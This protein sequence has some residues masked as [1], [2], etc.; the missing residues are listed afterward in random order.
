[1]VTGGMGWTETRLDYEENPDGDLR[2]DRI[3]PF[4]MIWDCNA[5]KKNL[6]D[7]RRFWHVRRLPIN[8][9][10]RLPG[11]P[12]G[13]DDADLNAD[14][15][16]TAVWEGGEDHDGTKVRDRTRSNLGEAGGD[17]DEVVIVHCQWQEV[18][19][20]W[21]VPIPG[22]G[23]K[24]FKP[25]EYKAFKKQFSEKLMGGEEPTDE[26]LGAIRQKQKVWYRAIL[27]NKV[28]V[29]TPCAC[30]KH[31]NFKAITG[32]R[33]QTK[34]QWFGLVRP[35]RDPQTWSNKFFSQILHIINSNAKGGIMA[36]R[37]QAFDNDADAEQSW[38]RQDRITWFKAGALSGPSQKWAEKPQ[39]QFPQALQS[40]MEYAV[41][42]VRATGGVSYE[43]IGRSAGEPR[44]SAPAS[45][46]DDPGAALR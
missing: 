32:K 9:A 44:I 36:E 6:I 4:E 42:A 43:F 1:M 40:L 25:D 45:G 46:T 28:L 18:E 21:S 29:V 35:M 13:V 12:A 15:A 33:H 39:T 27:G 34:N 20:F 23:R 37:G 22:A 38:A 41:D 16:D 8:E 17:L 7:A 2:D 14:W 24:Q 31:S 3:D 11:V 10:R 5:T 19:S 26:Q 30:P